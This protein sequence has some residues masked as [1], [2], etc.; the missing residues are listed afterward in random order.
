MG[1]KTHSRVSQIEAMRIVPSKAAQRYLSA[2]ATFPNV[3]EA[4]A[5]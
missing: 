1:L 4:V 2:L 3:V 5:S